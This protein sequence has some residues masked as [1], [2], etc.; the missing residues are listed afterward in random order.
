MQEK[1]T[2]DLQ[3]LKNKHRRIEGNNRITEAEKCTNS[4]EDRMMEITAA[5]PNIDKIMKR[6][7]VRNLWDNIKCT[8]IHITGVPEGGERERDDLRKYFKR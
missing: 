3:E 7:G 1:F 8:N 6:T 4:L 2:K 5:V